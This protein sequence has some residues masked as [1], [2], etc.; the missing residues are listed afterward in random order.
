MA[1]PAKRFV[2]LAAGRALVWTGFWERVL[3]MWARRRATL[4]LTYH[5]VIEK[6]DETLDYSQPGMVVTVP[7]FE[8]Q[9]AFMKSQFEI[10]PLGALLENGAIR[11]PA[12]RPRCVITFDDGWRDNYDLAL[13]I[14]RHHR[15]PAT[16]FVTTDF[17]GTGRVFWHTTLSRMLLRG[18]LSQLL[19]HEAELAAYPSPVRHQLQQLA[20]RGRAATARDV[21]PIIETIKALCGQDAI[22]ALL[23][24]LSWTVGLSTRAVQDQNY[25]LDWDQ[26]REMAAGG[27]E[28]GS[29]GCSHRIMTGLSIDE[30]SEELVRSKREIE[31]RI[32]RGVAHFAFP[33]GAANGAIVAAAATAGYRTACLDG[34]PAGRGRH[35]ILALRRVGMHEEVGG[36]G[37]VGDDA[38]LRL[39]LA[40]A[41]KVVPA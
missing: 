14:L 26:V 11:R 1:V 5:R 4:I 41:P 39:W 19:R 38:L 16:I 25:F 10:V 15:I 32:G 28:I 13:P 34:V 8:R 20:R 37:P 21:D 36:A 35:G 2:K 3:R 23:Q 9:L 17:I 33:N 24:T 29:H 22:E 12:G 18:D 6:W 31:H 7:T 30:A 40:R 27:I